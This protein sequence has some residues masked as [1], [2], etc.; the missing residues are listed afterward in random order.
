MAIRQI[1]ATHLVGLAIGLSIPL[2]FASDS[3]KD[4]ATENHLPL[5]KGMFASAQQANRCA[6]AAR[7]QAERLLDFHYGAD[8][9]PTNIDSVKALR[10]MRHPRNPKVMLDVLEVHAW[11]YKSEF[12]MRFRYMYHRLNN[13][14]CVLVGQEIFEY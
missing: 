2:A 8:H 3:S 11:I 1:F 12:R 5:S 4:I 13:P 6:E 9:A 10:P 14:T 7:E